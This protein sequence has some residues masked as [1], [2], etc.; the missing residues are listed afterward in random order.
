MK[1]ASITIRTDSDFKQECD[2]LFKQMG[3]TT[4]TAI[5]AFLHQ[6][7]RDRRFPFIP[8]VDSSDVISEFVS[9]LPEAGRVASK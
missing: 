4:Q 5:N 3:M 9:N 2:E 6:A 1:T 8:S 7:V